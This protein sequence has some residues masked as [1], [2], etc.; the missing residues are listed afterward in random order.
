MSTSTGLDLGDVE[1]VVD[2]VEHM[3]ARIADVM[4][5]FEIARAADRAEPF[6]RHHFGKA[7]DGVERGADFVADPGKEIALV[8]IR[9]LRGALG[10]AQLFFGAFP[11][12]DVTQNRA[13]AVRAW[14]AFRWS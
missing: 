4:G 2:D 3:L 13:I 10:G 1:Q 8:R 11:L 12:G 9:G 5:I 7:D 14:K 6:L